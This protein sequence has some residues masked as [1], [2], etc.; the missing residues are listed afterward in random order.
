MTCENVMTY[1][2]ISPVS[3]VIVPLF[4][5]LDL[6]TYNCGLLEE[7]YTLVFLC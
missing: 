7:K 5:Q 1:L 4:V 2:N 6:C 3:S